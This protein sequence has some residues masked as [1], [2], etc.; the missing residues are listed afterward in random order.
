MA[1]KKAAT[2]K[3]T[4][5]KKS[6]A[7]K[8]P[9]AKKAVPAK[10][11]ALE[12]VALVDAV[13]ELVRDEGFGVFTAWQKRL[14]PKKPTPLASSAIAKLTIAKQSLPP[15]LAR[16]LSFH[17][18]FQ[19]I[20]F[21][22]LDWAGKPLPDLLDES[23]GPMARFLFEDANPPL[24]GVAVKLDL[25]SDYELQ[26]ILAGK[27]D[28]AGELPILKVYA[29]QPGRSFVELLNPGFDAYIASWLQP[30]FARKLGVDL[31][32]G[33]FARRVKHH[34]AANFG[35]KRRYTLGR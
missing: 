24:N 25:P 10:G 3:K 5:A 6:A 18:T 33:P 7:K 26:A 4:P 34:V 17:S 19:E 8:A 35:G 1:T 12:G 30:K 27:P 13:I 2:A 15:S 28:D 22:D 21:G 23:M 14:V 11:G 31:E 16:W 29:N 20:D 32:G 9:P